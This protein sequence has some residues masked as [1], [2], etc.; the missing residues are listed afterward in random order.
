MAIRQFSDYVN[1]KNHPW[2]KH[3]EDYTLMSIGEYDD[4]SAEIRTFD[5]PIVHGIGV[6]FL[7]T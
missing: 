3:P 4:E 6:K 5:V 1:D 2:G 7:D